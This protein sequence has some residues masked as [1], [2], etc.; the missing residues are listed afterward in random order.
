MS[1]MPAR[2]L[3]GAVAAAAIT[4]AISVSL[5]GSAAAYQCKN[6]FVQAE[7]IHKLP[8]KAR[9]AAKAAWT[10]KVKNTYGLAWSVWDI[11]ASKSQ[12]CSFTGGAFYCIYKAKPCL[13]V[14]Q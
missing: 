14:V 7:A 2:N 5:A 11:A 9:A 13:H 8:A 1:T 6:N 10:A 3:I 4:A 12:N